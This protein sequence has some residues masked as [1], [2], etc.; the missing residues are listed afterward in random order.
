MAG[1]SQFSM[2]QQ[3]DIFNIFSKFGIYNCIIVS[4]E[5]YVIDKEYSRQTNFNN[6]ETDMKLGVYTW[7]PYQSSDCC[8]EVN[9]ITLMD[10]WVIS[11]QGNFTKNTDLFT[12]KISD[13]LN[14]CPMKAVVRDSR[15]LFTTYYKTELDLN[16]SVVTKIFGMEMNLL[17]LVLKQINMTFVHVPT[18]EGFETQKRRTDN[19]TLRLL[20]SYIWSS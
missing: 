16:G 7:F 1:S 6:A 20:M 18:P 12:G 11:A 3:T 15:W 4:Q 9:D 17:M 5:H 19:L 10:S 2:S 13:S 14:V 8:T